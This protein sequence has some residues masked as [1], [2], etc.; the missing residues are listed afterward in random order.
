[1]VEFHTWHNLAVT[2]MEF[3]ICKLFFIFDRTVSS[4]PQYLFVKGVT[5]KQFFNL[6]S[7]RI[8]DLRKHLKRYKCCERCRG[9]IFHKFFQL[10]CIRVTRLI[11]GDD[12]NFGNRRRYNSIFDGL[13]VLKD[14]NDYGYFGV[15]MVSCHFMQQ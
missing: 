2:R 5:K 7:K 4:M 15:L 8:V 1:M 6:M 13:I 12:L 10:I 3:S 9:S 14:N 11:G